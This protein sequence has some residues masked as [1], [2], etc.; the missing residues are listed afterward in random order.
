MILVKDLFE[1]Y[2]KNQQYFNELFKVELKI[3]KRESTLGV[4]WKIILG[5]IIIIVLGIIFN[6]GFY[7][8]NYYLVYLAMNY[9]LWQFIQDT[10]NDSPT[11]FTTHRNVLE[12]NDI[13]PLIFIIK[14]VCINFYVYLFSCSITILLF[15]YFDLI[16]FKIFLSIFAIIFV[17]INALLGSIIL[18]YLQEKFSD[19]NSL[20]KLITLILFLS[21]PIIWSEKIF[22]DFSQ[23]LLKLNPL[24]HFFKIYN[25]PIINDNLDNQYFT[26]LLV[27]IITT[28]ANIIITNQIYKANKF[29]TIIFN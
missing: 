8:E 28:I 25:S 5:L 12:N 10:L 17:F 22:N 23:F 9:Y 20:I 15:M 14:T 18:S 4:F 2:I 16:T 11:T 19:V 3:R 6:K 24:F 26:S 7:K 29:K 13:S 1:T 27:V 21:T